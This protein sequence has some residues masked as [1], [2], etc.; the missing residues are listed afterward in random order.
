[1]APIINPLHPSFVDKLDPQ[2]AAIYNKHQAPRL[3]ADQVTIEEFRAH[4][5][6]YTST[7]TPGPCPGVETANVHDVA[8]DQPVGTIQVK[9][10]VPTASQIASG[11]LGNA[12]A[13]LPAHVNFHGGGWVIGSLATDES[14]CRQTCSRLGCVVVDVNYRHGPEYPFPAAVYD[15]FTALKWVF[16]APVS[17]LKDID[18]SRVSVGGLSAGGHLSAVVTHLARD[19]GLPRLVKQVLVVPCVDMRWVPMEGSAEEGCPYEKYNSCEFAPCLPLQ[20][21][22][23][24]FDCWVGK[25]AEKRKELVNTPLA[26]PILFPSHEGLAPASIHTAEFDLLCSEAEVYHKELLKAGTPSVIKVYKG[27]GHPFAHWD[28]ELEIGRECINDQLEVLKKA[29]QI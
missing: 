21:M 4:P 5:E 8:V 2:F 3:R 19:A 12:D 14:F 11:G 9:I 10:Y 24:F 1:M 26:S 18:T 25:N 6:K 15:A 22:R 28:G 17:D 23:W 7:I 29:Y 16:A 13:K 27:V 20:R